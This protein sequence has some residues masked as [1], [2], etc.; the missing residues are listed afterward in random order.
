MREHMCARWEREN[1]SLTNCK[2]QKLFQTWIE[3]ETNS[4]ASVCS[5]NNSRYFTI[6]FVAWQ[7]VG[8]GDPLK[9][10]TYDYMPPV[11][12]RVRYWGEGSS[13]RNK[14]D[15]LLLGVPSKKLSSIKQKEK[16]SYGPIKR[17]YYSPPYQNYYSSLH[18]QQQQP[19]YVSSLNNIF[20]A[21]I[22]HFRCFDSFRNAWCH[23]RGT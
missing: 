16:F 6:A 14:N 11:L 21:T 5:Q 3:R 19:Q 17:T 23:L 2:S 9:D 12:D 7:P 15:I 10:P 4:Y 8:R 20:L 18:Q 13:N 22:F 1:V